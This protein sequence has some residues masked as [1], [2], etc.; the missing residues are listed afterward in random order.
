MKR[1]I[2]L[3]ESDLHRVIK[4]SVN[5]VLNERKK[6]SNPK[7]WNIDG[8]EYEETNQIKGGGAW[9]PGYRF[10]DHESHLPER[11]KRYRKRKDGYR[12]AQSYE[13][14][15]H[16]LHRNLTIENKVLR[17]NDDFIPHGYKGTSNLGGYEIQI[18]DYGDGARLRDSYTGKVSDWLEIQFD[19]EGVAYVIDANGNEERLCDYMRY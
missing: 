4:E 6:L 9:H 8:V 10:K 5:T 15:P 18:N 19:E 11:L 2:R 16:N 7:K 17:E 14:Y 1:R 12:Y 13:S 3:T